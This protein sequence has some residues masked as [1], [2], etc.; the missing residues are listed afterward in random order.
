MSFKSTLRLFVMV[1]MLVATALQVSAKDEVPVETYVVYNDTL[2]T[3]YCDNNKNNRVGEIVE[4]DGINNF[5]DFKIFKRVVKKAI[6]DSSFK[7]ARPHYTDHWFDS[8]EQLKEVIGLE[9]LN[10]SEIESMDYMFA[11]C[12]RLEKIDMSCLSNTPKL[13][14]A[15]KMFYLCYRLKKIDISN[16]DATNL[17]NMDYMFLY[18]NK[19]ESVSLPY[20]LKIIGEEAFYKCDSLKKADIPS[21]VLRIKDSAFCGCNFKNIVIPN[22]VKFI[23]NGVFAGCKNATSAEIPSSVISMGYW[24]LNGCINLKH[25]YSNI[26]VPYASDLNNFNEYPINVTLHV[27]AGTKTQY[28]K[29]EGWDEF[30]NIVETTTIPMYAVDNEGTLTFYFDEYMYKR[31]GKVYSPIRDLT[32][33]YYTEFSEYLNFKKGLKK[34]VFDDSFADARPE[35]TEDWFAACNNIT[36]IVNIKN[37]NTTNV[38]NMRGMFGS[39]RNLKEIDLSNFVTNKVRFMDRMFA[40]C[41]GIT[42]LNLSNFNTESLEFFDSMFSG[43]SNL[44]HLNISS[45]KTNNIK[46]MYGLFQECSSLTNLDLSKFNTSNVTLMSN[47]FCGCSSLMNLDLSKFDTSNV[48]SMNEM[49]NGCSS[50]T[51]LDLSN[52]NTSNVT[53]MYKMF[54]GCSSLSRLNLSNFNTSN[55]TDM[56]QMFSNCEK[57]TRLDFRNFDTD[58]ATI[59]CDGCSSLKSV[60]IGENIKQMPHLYGCNKIKRIISYQITPQQFPTYCIDETVKENAKLYVPNNSMTIYKNT[61]GWK[62]FKHIVAMELDFE[63]SNTELR[64]GDL[65]ENSDLDGNIIGNIFYNISE[66]IG[67]Y[68]ATEGCIILKKATTEEQIQNSLG[69]DLFDYYLYDNFTGMIFMVD[70]GSGTIEL[71]AETVGEMQLSVMVGTAEPITKQTSGKSKVS[72]PY[73]VAEPTLVYVYGSMPA[74][75]SAKGIHKANAAENALKIYSAAWGKATGIRSIYGENGSEATIYNMN[76]QRVKTPGKG[77][78]IVNGKKVILK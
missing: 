60:S 76:G 30:K 35:S 15:E 4:E 50:L 34:V 70:A 2:M 24:L 23:G 20:N 39:C 51:D 41:N 32:S 58:N 11:D 59:D 69:K 8:C 64:K 36:E 40:A 12:I 31:Q 71:E 77:L 57:L 75:Q 19:L 78:Y 13:R 62:E 54:Y 53:N 16:M 25:I 61:D 28:Q 52:F 37:L 10:T 42:E 21:T 47:M 3:F 18:C 33:D 9:N 38:T 48:T 1:V 14:S 7:K 73:D 45:F 63:D 5:G 65:D 49:F 68:N 26:G 6:F 72:I 46:S 55:V 29:T 66:E 17:T 22:N 67:K 44:K 43:C 27:P 74:A 56:H